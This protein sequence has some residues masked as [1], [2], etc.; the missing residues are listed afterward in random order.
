MN[1]TYKTVFFIMSFVS[2][3]ANNNEKCGEKNN[4]QHRINKN[5]IHP[6][7]SS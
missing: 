2:G 3:A 4:S 6:I 5:N 7:L 1:N